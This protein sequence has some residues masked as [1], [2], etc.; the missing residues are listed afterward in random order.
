MSSDEVLSVTAFLIS[1]SR[2][3]RYSR[4]LQLAQLPRSK[5]QPASV[6][7]RLASV[8]RGR[9]LYFNKFKCATCHPLDT[10]GSSLLAPNL[11]GVGL[12]RR[13][14]LEESIRR[15]STTIPA[16]YQ[17]CQVLHDGLVVT[18]R[19]LPAG[20]DRVRLLSSDEDGIHVFEFNEKDLEPLDGA[21]RVVA[22]PQSQMPALEQVSDEELASLLDFLATLR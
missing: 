21:S 10:S 5:H 16:S 4:L 17:S 2:E 6:H 9:D 20:P 15:P 7:F 13:E 8:E 18:G 11:M 1:Q 14:F 19:R 22:L 3:P 12:H